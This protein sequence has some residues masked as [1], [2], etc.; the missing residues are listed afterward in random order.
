MLAVEMERVRLLEQNRL[1]KLENNII[2][3]ITHGL[4]QS[5]QCVDHYLAR[6]KSPKGKVE[7]I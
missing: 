4:W 1:K 5:S 6:I 7:A 2:D 3:I